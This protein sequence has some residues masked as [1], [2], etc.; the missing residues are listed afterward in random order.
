MKKHK[1]IVVLIKPWHTLTEQTMNLLTTNK[2]LSCFKH[3][4]K[5]LLQSSNYNQD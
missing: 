1:E 5:D 4:D 2:A 3:D